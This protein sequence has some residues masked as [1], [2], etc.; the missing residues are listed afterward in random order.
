MDMKL[1]KNED[2]CKYDWMSKIFT[3][4]NSDM[5]GAASIILLGNIFSRMDYKQT[6]FGNFK[7]QYL[8]WEKNFYDEYEK[9]F[10]VGMVLDQQLINKLDDPKLVFISDRGDKLDVYDSTL[11]SEDCSS[12][13]KLIYNKFKKTVNF[14]Q[15]IKKLV[16]YVDDYNDYK[17]KFTESEYLNG[18]YRKYEYDR[19]NKFVKRFWGGY[20]GFTDK[21]L[22][23]AEEYFSDVEKEVAKLELFSGQYKDWKVI[24]TISKMPVNEIAKQIIDNYDVDV[25]IVVN[26]DTSFVSFRKGLGS[27]ADIPYIATKLCD[28][29]G[30]EWAAGGTITKTFEEFT[31]TLNLI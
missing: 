15:N 13:V 27:N 11:I 17:L 20:D 29:G 18:L 25:V 9:I 1:E 4:V 23:R 28:G 14:S 19:F 16:L 26:L 2:I 6:F 22:V 12:C 7:E 30:G 24:L 31:Q 5:D 10:I 8:E 21:E 3:W